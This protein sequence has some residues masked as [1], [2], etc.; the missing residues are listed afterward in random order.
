MAA[1]ICKVNPFKMPKKFA[2]MSIMALTTTSSAICLPT[3]ME[4][5]TVKFGISR[6][7]TDFT[8]PITMY[9]NAW[10]T[11][12]LRTLL[13]VDIDVLVGMMRWLLGKF[14]IL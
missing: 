4:D 10:F 13:N 3:K 6:K 5:M 14:W 9:M 11:G 8:G 1:V 12:M 2:K 7:V